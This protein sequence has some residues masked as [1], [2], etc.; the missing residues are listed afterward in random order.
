MKVVQTGKVRKEEGVDNILESRA[1]FDIEVIQRSN[2]GSVSLKHH[3]HSHQHLPV[4]GQGICQRYR[5]PDR[6]PLR[7]SN[8]SRVHRLAV[9]RL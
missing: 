8:E 2:H 6:K 7:T 9:S 3:S 5:R 4:G 1:L